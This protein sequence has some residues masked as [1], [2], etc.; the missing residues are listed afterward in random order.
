MVFGLLLFAGGFVVYTFILGNIDGKPPLEI[1]RLPAKGPP[2]S[3]PISDGSEIPLPPDVVLKKAFGPLAKELQ[4]PL[5]LWLP[6]KGVVF[7][8]SQ[9]DIDKTDGRVRLA[10]FS[11]AIF[12]KS[13][14]PGAFPEI[15]TITCD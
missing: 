1:N 9:F 15:S 5:R 4:R 14:T 2:D 12:H 3:P 7:A 10:P 13:K 11:A 6:D 8:A